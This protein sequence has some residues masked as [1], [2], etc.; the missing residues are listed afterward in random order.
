MATRHDQDSKVNMTPV[1]AGGYPKWFATFSE[2]LAEA[3]GYG[4]SFVFKLGR[5]A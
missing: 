4:K 2:V 1:M 3:W 5:N